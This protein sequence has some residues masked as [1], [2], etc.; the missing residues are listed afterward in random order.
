MAQPINVLAIELWLLA[1]SAAGE[2][3]HSTKTYNSQ[4]KSYFE[5]RQ[6]NWL[7][8]PYTPGPWPKARALAASLIL[9]SVR[10]RLASA[11][12]FLP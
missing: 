6:D 4:T 10:G 12:R 3:P 9:K 8:P 1:A 7:L 11:T 5:L 2:P